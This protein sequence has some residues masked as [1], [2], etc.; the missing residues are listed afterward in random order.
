VILH[1]FDKSNLCENQIMHFVS[2]IKNSN[3]ENSCCNHKKIGTTFD[4]KPTICVS[5]TNKGKTQVGWATTIGWRARRWT[6]TNNVFPNGSLYC[7]PDSNKMTTKS[8][9]QEAW[10]KIVGMG[11]HKIVEWMRNVNLENRTKIVTLKK[12]LTM[13]QIECITNIHL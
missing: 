13:H 9:C 1:V 4:A 3:V 12:W 8:P 6:R 10:K 5:S 7:V 11:V 2:C